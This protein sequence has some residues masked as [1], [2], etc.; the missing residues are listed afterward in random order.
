MM[1]QQISL[2]TLGVA[3]F[4][5]SRRFYT[6]GFGWTPVFELPGIAFFQMNGLVFGIWSA[7]ALA[8]DMNR[9]ANA[10]GSI[11][12]AH[13]VGSPEEV[14]SLMAKLTSAGAKLLRAGDA[15]VHGG[16]RGY[17]A[18]PDGHAWEIAW[19]PAWSIDSQGHVRF[20]A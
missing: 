2:I 15:P 6:E 17:V 10:P 14:E 5:A 11:A 16:Y 3:D 19:N 18:D 8:E 1:L 20:S 7:E 12:L 9:P 13:N 4:A